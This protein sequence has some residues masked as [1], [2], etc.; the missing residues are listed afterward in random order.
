[1]ITSFY[2]YGHSIMEITLLWL[3]FFKFNATGNWTADIENERRNGFLEAK[4]FKMFKHFL[5]LSKIF[6]YS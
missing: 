3:L 4:Y 5:G 1:M 2:N 6:A